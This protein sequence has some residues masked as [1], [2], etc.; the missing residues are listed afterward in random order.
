MSV[1]SF[2]DYKRRKAGCWSEKKQTER[3]ALD[4]AICDMR[5]AS[6]LLEKFAESTIDS[7]SCVYMKELAS[8]LKTS[9]LNAA[10]ALMEGANK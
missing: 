10:V 1:V 9:A 8:C 3:Q 7:E 6:N 2:S 4:K 5:A